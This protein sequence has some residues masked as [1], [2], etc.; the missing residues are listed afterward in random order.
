MSTSWSRPPGLAT[1]T[2]NRPKRRNSLSEAYMR[3][4]IAALGAV[5]AHA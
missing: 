4:L 5:S 1:I 3:E 2:M